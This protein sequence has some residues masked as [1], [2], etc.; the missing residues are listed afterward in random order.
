MMQSVREDPDW[1][2]RKTAAQQ[3]TDYHIAGR[4]YDR[5]A[6]G[7]ESG[8]STWDDECPDC[9]VQPGELHVPGCDVERCPRCK[10]QSISCVCPTEEEDDLAPGPG[11]TDSGPGWM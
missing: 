4:L 1:Q 8:W 2:A 3:E 6:F 7:S 10:A 9:G 5:L 11:G